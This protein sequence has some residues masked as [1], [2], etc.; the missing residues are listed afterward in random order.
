MDPIQFGLESQSVL[1]VVEVIE[2]QDLCYYQSDPFI[3][4]DPIGE[5]NVLEL[6]L[7]GLTFEIRKYDD[8]VSLTYLMAN[9]A[10]VVRQ[11][12]AAV[13]YDGDH[14]VLFSGANGDVVGSGDQRGF[15]DIYGV[16]I[17]DPMVTEEQYVPLSTWTN[18]YFT[19][20]NQDWDV[21]DLWNGKYVAITDPKGERDSLRENKYLSKNSDRKARV[22][23]GE[24][25]AS[26]SGPKETLMR[27]LKTHG[28]REYYPQLRGVHPGEHLY[29]ESESEFPNYYLVPLV[30]KGKVKAVGMVNAEKGTF[31]GV[32]PTNG[33]SE[34]Y[35][36]IFSA[37]ARNR[38]KEALGISEIGTPKLTWRPCEESWSPYR[39]FWTAKT[40]NDRVH[41]DQNGIVHK[42]LH[43]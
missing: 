5:R 12:A 13:V 37:Q 26:N 38:I 15:C 28:L 19:V 17:H 2:E 6:W 3:G 32:K 23:K 24:N 20:F 43:P 21:D 42:K 30:R 8:G 7:G 4:V 29:V 31:M 41:L 34:N 18:S 9:I 27:G 36:S 10:L 35:L 1:I 25:L 39:P 22:G 16:F 11:P 14:M 33:E 40:G